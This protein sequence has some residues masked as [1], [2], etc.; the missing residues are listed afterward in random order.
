ML[1]NDNYTVG[2]LNIL[3]KKKKKKNSLFLP[4]YSYFD[5]DSLAKMIAIKTVARKTMWTIVNFLIF[6]INWSWDFIWFFT[7]VSNISKH[8]M[9]KLIKHKQSSPFMSLAHSLILQ[10]D[11]GKSKWNTRILVSLHANWS[12]SPI[13][14]TRIKVW[15]KAKLT[16]INSQTVSVC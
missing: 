8:N 15:F 1:P 5:C 13:N 6:C 4:I 16:Y 10:S 9:S 3:V 2:F 7:K 12:Q 11:G 14:E